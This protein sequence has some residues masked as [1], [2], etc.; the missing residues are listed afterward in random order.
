MLQECTELERKGLLL[1][2]PA[3]YI[4]IPLVSVGKSGQL[5]VWETIYT[6]QINTTESIP[7]TLTNWS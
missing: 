1:V 3:L 2:D 4:I 6:Q 5:A 7:L